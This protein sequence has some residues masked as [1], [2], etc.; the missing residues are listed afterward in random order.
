MQALSNSERMSLFQRS[1]LILKLS[2]LWVDFLS[3]S[4]FILQTAFYIYR[5]LG[6][7]VMK[8]L[9]MVFRKEKS[10]RILS[11][12]SKVILTTMLSMVIIGTG[13]IFVGEYLTSLDQFSLFNKFQVALFQFVAAQSTSGFNTVNFANLQPYSLYLITLIMF[14]GG[15][16]GSTAGGI[17]ITTLAILVQSVKTTLYSKE[18][19]ELFERSLQ[20][21]IVVKAVT[22]TMISLLIVSFFVFLML[23]L[24]PKQTFLALSF[25]V[26]SAFGTVGLSLGITGSL[27]LAGKIAV[28]S[29]I[30]AGR[31]RKRC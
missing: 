11:M 24:E 2:F 18:E 21:S 17:K 27:S 5:G 9:L 1:S 4:S 28:T 12:H 13:T 8:E 25:E 14:I 20:T 31:W 29:Y 3:V 10:L 19:V 22:I 26:L 16:P 30:S 15:S 6:F 23:L 7:I